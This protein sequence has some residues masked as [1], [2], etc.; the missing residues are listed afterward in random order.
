MLKVACR[1]N[2]MTHLSTISDRTY[3]VAAARV[4]NSLPVSVTSAATH[5]KFKQQLK[6]E[7]YIRC[8]D[9]LSFHACKQSI[10]ILLSL[11][12]YPTVAQLILLFYARQ[13]ICY[14]AYMPRQFRPS[15]CPSVCPSHACIVSKRLNVSSKFFH[16][17]IGPSF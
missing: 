6:T 7:P 4:W 9:L 11:P 15:V 10:H 5:N 16:C 17:P 14:S 8:Y 2:G 3:P 1:C 12:S 13:H